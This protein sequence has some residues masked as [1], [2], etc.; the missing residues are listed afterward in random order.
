M[1][2]SKS[3]LLVANSL[4]P[5]GAFTGNE[6]PVPDKELPM[7]KEIRSRTAT[8]GRMDDLFGTRAFLKNDGG[9]RVTGA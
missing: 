5:L 4:R 1:Y 2:D 8:N 3:Q 9:A 7:D 6:T